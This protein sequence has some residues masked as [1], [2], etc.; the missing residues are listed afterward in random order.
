MVLRL[1]CANNYDALLVL[2]NVNVI[3]AQNKT[4]LKKKRKKQFK[5]RE[6]FIFYKLKNDVFRVNIY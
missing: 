1:K 2:Q 6:M 4:K 3:R 5:R